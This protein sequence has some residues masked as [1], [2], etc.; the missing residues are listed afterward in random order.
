MEIFVDNEHNY[1]GQS[2]HHEQQNVNFQNAIPNTNAPSVN[3]KL[4][5][6][7]L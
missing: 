1:F 7:F 2:G 4:N 6:Y 5:V 3:C